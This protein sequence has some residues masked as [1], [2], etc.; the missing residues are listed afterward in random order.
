MDVVMIQY[1]DD[2]GVCYCNSKCHSVPTIDHV[3]LIFN[4]WTRFL[5]AP[6]RKLR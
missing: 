6:L 5:A 4:D 1:S 2:G 3:K